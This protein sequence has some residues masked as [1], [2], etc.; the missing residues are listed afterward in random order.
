M[1]HYDLTVRDSDGSVVQFLYGE[2]GLDVPKT[3]FL[4]AKQFPFIADNYKVTFFLLLPLTNR[5]LINFIV[6]CF[7]FC[8]RRMYSVIVTW[9]FHWETI[10]RMHL[11]N[12][13]PNSV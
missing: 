8:T 9:H 11:F 6:L 13:F 10:L 2:D 7:I 4:Q 3:Q 5:V 12:F 1:V